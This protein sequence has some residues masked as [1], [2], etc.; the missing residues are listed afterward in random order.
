MK[1]SKLAT[2][3]LTS[4][5]FMSA[6]G[7]EADEPQSAESIRAQVCTDA[8]VD[9]SKPEADLS[10]SQ[11]RAL[12]R[13]T[14]QAERVAANAEGAEQAGDEGVICRR[15][16]MTG[17]HQRVRICTTRAQR[18]AMR[19]SARETIRDVTRP[20]GNFGNETQ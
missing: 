3:L 5:M 12:R 14:E 15:E 17:T 18:D 19:N 4:V 11:R 13:C 1:L 16:S 8:G 9:L 6:Q 2:V 10:R 20:G 7:Q